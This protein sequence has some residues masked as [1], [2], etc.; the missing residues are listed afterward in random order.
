MWIKGKVLIALTL[1]IYLVVGCQSARPI[2]CAFLSAAPID[3]EGEL[4]NLKDASV[5]APSEGQW[6]LKRDNINKVRLSTHPRMGQMTSDLPKYLYAGNSFSLMILAAR[7]Q[8]IDVW[9]ADDL[10][11]FVERWLR[12]GMGLGP[13]DELEPMVDFL[14]GEHWKPLELTVTEEDLGGASCVRFHNISHSSGRLQSV[15]I[16]G[17][18]CRH[19]EN[20]LYLVA[21]YFMEHFAPGGQLDGGAF[22]RMSER[23]GEPF[24]QSLRFLPL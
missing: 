3:Q 18:V 22:E 7:I 16:V 21:V 11:P 14:S 9:E 17:F 1:V 4:I 5:E 10:K 2:D 20:P 23:F 6:C 13:I 12:S 19:P 24:F 15:Q 8:S